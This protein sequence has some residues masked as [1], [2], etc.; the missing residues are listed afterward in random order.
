M[1]KHGTPGVERNPVV[2]WLL[3]FCFVVNFIWIY[4]VWTEIA[5]FTK[6]DINP[7]LKTALMLVPLVNI[8]IVYQMFA[9]ISEMEEMVGVP[10]EESLNPI[11]NLLFCFL[12][13]IGI[14]YA[15]NHLN[16]VWDRA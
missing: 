15:Q 14:M 8:I 5:T 7:M 3:S 1:V 13:L 2:W 6:K 12:F 11:I 9:E 16:G 4:R 10:E